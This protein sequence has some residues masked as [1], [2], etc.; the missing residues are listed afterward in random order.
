MQQTLSA[1]SQRAQDLDRRVCPKCKGF[2]LVNWSS[3]MA[4][5]RAL[6]KAK[7]ARVFGQG[8]K[9]KNAPRVSLYARVSTHDQ[10]TLP[11]QLDSMRSYAARRGWSIISETQGVGSGAVQR[12]ERELLM[13]AARRR[14]L[15][16][17]LV[18]RLDRWRRSAADLALTLKELNELGVALVSLT[19]ALDLTTPTGRAMAGLLSVFAEF[20]RE[21]LRERIIAGLVQARRKG[22]PLGRPRSTFCMQAQAR[23]F[24]EG[25]SKTD[26]SRRLAISHASVRR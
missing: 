10:Q 18:W 25:L 12:P 23:A 5:K 8:Q 15:D 20:E 16:I 6:K 9:P 2:R 22:T 11:L 4:A 19:E 1:M 13:E 14:E 24:F 21:V 17:I 26:I 7:P 3:K